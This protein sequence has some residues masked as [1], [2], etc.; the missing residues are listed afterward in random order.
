MQQVKSINTGPEMIVRRLLHGMSYRYRLHGEKLPGKPD[1]VFAGRRKVVFV[2][3]CFW[4]GHVCRRGSRVH[5]CE[6]RWWS[7]LGYGCATS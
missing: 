3:G 4:H 2:Q 7:L 5:G 6:P 1:L